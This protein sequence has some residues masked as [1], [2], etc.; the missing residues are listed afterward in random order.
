MQAAGVEKRDDLHAMLAESD[1]VSIHCVL[2]DSTR[3]LIGA[4][5]FARMK[6]GAVLINVARGAVVDEDALLGSLRS[7]RLG[8]AGL[9]VYSSEPLNR[10]THALAPLFE[11][12]NVILLPHL[13]FFTHEAMQRLEE[14]A[15]QRCD[16]LLRGEPV[17]VKSRDPRLTSQQY[18][19]RFD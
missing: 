17:L 14:E 18:G 11:M 9:D 12:D 4:R 16:E 3:G 6:P 10:T 15:L 13:T 8:G 1:F 5:E 2:N 7:G 19:V